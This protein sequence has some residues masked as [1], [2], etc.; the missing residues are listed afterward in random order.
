MSKNTLPRHPKSLYSNDHIFA[1]R[2]YNKISDR[3]FTHKLTKSQYR[4]RRWQGGYLPISLSPRR[5][6]RVNKISYYELR[7]YYA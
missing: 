1:Q 2:P 5:S 6:A 3:I 4:M 7:K